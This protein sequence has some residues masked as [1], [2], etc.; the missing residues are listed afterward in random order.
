MTD[1]QAVATAV[2]EKWKNDAT[3][4]FSKGRW[5]SVVPEELLGD[6]AATL[7][8]RERE[9]WEDIDN[10]FGM[11]GHRVEYMRSSTWEIEYRE[12]ADYVHE[13]AECRPQGG[14]G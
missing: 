2:V 14:G 7:D 9:V 11:G 10:R 3:L 4:L 6:I 5:Y 1:T 13:K 8:A 12:I